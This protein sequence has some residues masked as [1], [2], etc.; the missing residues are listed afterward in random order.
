MTCM[1]FSVYLLS[2]WC[3]GQTFPSSHARGFVTMSGIGWRLLV[4]WGEPPGLICTLA[5]CPYHSIY[6]KIESLHRSTS[7]TTHRHAFWLWEATINHFFSTDEQGMKNDLIQKCTLSP[8][9]PFQLPYRPITFYE[10]HP[11]YIW[12]VEYS[13]CCTALWRVGERV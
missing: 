13:L 2:E 6:R 5:H 11:P 12:A 8:Q 7:A 1:T 10:S 9:Q 4:C 3:K